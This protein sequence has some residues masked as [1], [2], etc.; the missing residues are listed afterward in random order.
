M[1][2]YRS[3]GVA[4]WGNSLRGLRSGTANLSGSEHSATSG[5]KVDH[6]DERP[7][8]DGKGKPTP[9]QIGK[10][11]QNEENVTKRSNAEG[12]RSKSSIRE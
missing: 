12:T 7:G 6:S 4:G 11:R 8:D 1:L 9:E 10:L 3:G 5:R 2:S